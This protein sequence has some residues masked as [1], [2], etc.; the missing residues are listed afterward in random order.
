MAL[1][2]MSSGSTLY[3]LDYKATGVSEDIVQE[4]VDSDFNGLKDPRMYAGLRNIGSYACTADTLKTCEPIEVGEELLIYQGGVFHP[5]IVPAVTPITDAVITP[6]MES[7]TL[8]KG[9]F[10]EYS[11]SS[12]YGGRYVTSFPS[13][14]YGVSLDNAADY[15][16]YRFENDELFTVTQYT[17]K[18]NNDGFI[19]KG[20]TNGVDWDTVDTRAAGTG[21]GIKTLVCASPGAYSRY[22]IYRNTTNLLL[23]S[24]YLLGDGVEIDTSSITAASIPYYV[25]RSNIDISTNGVPWVR[26]RINAEVENNPSLVIHD[27][28]VIEILCQYDDVV[29]TP[30]TNLTTTV[31]I[32]GISSRVY[33][34][35][36]DIWKEEDP[37]PPFGVSK[38]TAVDNAVT[39]YFPSEISVVGD[40]TVSCAVKI[41]GG[42]L[43][44]PDTVT[45]GTESIVFNF[46]ASTFQNGQ[47]ITFEYDASVGGD[48]LQSSDSE[49]LATGSYEVINTVI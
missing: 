6:K 11:T 40:L 12:G 10:S 48:I 22:R 24:W 35:T 17:V 4:L 26:N 20:S 30:T 1:T 46:P 3:A 5:F 27:T 16:E 9:T 44:Y 18:E 8:P 42:A 32:N 49:E 14:S 23:Y 45:A 15:I 28:D 29:L 19:L 31:E 41:D 7:N 25:Y 21:T 38:A 37:I 2:D 36:S 39:A 34:I 43:I 47:V 13:T 33:E